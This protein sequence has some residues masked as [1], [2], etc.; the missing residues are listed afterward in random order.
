ML[1]EANGRAKVAG[2]KTTLHRDVIHG[3][4][5]LDHTRCAIP[6]NVNDASDLGLLNQSS[7]S[8][9]SSNIQLI[10]ELKHKKSSHIKS[11]ENLSEGGDW[12]SHFPNINK[13]NVKDNRNKR[14]ALYN[15]AVEL[16]HHELMSEVSTRNMV[17][18][19]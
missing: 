15:H 12:T 17:I 5:V 6:E 10:D 14:V 18:D 2:Q 19:D 1:T 4:T 9:I 13:I 11:K 16:I 7:L 8:K 3:K